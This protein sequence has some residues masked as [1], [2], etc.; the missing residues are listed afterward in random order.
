MRIRNT[1]RAAAAKISTIVRTL[2]ERMK[3]ITRK[4]AK[5]ISAVPRSRMRNKKPMQA[6]VNTR[7]SV[8][9]FLV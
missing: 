7:N 5:N 6:P 9:F 4:V 1:P 2:P 8:I 3:A